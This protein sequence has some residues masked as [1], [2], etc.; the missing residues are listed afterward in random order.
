MPDPT[1]KTVSATQIASLFNQSPYASRWMMWQEFRGLEMDD[2]PNERMTWGKRLEMPIIEAAAEE[3]RVDVNWNHRG[4]YR[5][6]GRIGCTID[7]DFT[8]PEH[9]PTVIEAKNVDWLQ[10]KD[11]WTETAAPPHIEL[12]IQAQMHVHGARFGYIAVLIGGNELRLYRREIDPDVIDLMLAEAEKFLAS[13]A[14]GAEPAAQDVAIEI[15]YLLALYPESEP[16]KWAEY[17][18]DDERSVAELINKYRY[19]KAQE[20][21]YKKLS[22]DAKAGVLKRMTDCQLMTAGGLTIR[23]DKSQVEETTTVRKAH[24]RTNIKVTGELADTFKEDFAA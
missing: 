2:D 17:D 3:L 4:E 20:S 16:E 15:P 21:F 1:K 11:K 22:A 9:G 10:W 12:Q 5:T 24:V 13:V 7:A 23:I 18:K 8:D 14:D 6:K 19:A